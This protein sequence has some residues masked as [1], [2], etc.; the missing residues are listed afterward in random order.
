MCTQ[1]VECIDLC[2]VQWEILH[3]L[4]VRAS[5]VPD[6]AL[7]TVILDLGVIE[8]QEGEVI[9]RQKAEPLLT[10]DMVAAS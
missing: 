8:V 5:A 4:N 6:S 9:A 10:L 7:S 3:C 2:A 1:G